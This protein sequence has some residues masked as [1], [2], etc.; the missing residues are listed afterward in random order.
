MYFQ[1]PPDGAA[2]ALLDRGTSSQ[3]AGNG[4]TRPRTK[5]ITKQV[6][7][8]AMRTPM[9]NGD[10]AKPNS[11]QSSK[12]K[13]PKE[14][15][16]EPDELTAINDRVN[17]IVRAFETKPLSSDDSFRTLGQGEF[18]ELRSNIDHLFQQQTAQSEGRTAML[19]NTVA[20]IDA[21]SEAGDLDIDQQDDESLLLMSDSKQGKVHGTL[22]EV[23]QHQRQSMA[24]LETVHK[25][26]ADIIRDLMARIKELQQ[27]VEEEH[28]KVLEQRQKV[29]DVTMSTDE[30][31]HDLEKH[32]DELNNAHQEIKQLQARLQKELEKPPPI[33]QIISEDGLEKLRAE[34]ERTKRKLGKAEDQLLWKA[35][36]LNAALEQQNAVMEQLGQAEAKQRALMEEQSL[37]KAKYESQ[38]IG[39]RETTSLL[40]QKMKDADEQ[41]A[42]HAAELL[43]VK[44][45]AKQAAEEA[46]TRLSEAWGSVHDQTGQ[47]EAEFDEQLAKAT[48]EFEQQLAAWR[49]RATKAELAAAE[50]EAKASAAA[51]VAQ[52]AAAEKAALEA[53]ALEAAS[54]AAAA[55]AA[56][57]QGAEQSGQ[58]E[59]SMVAKHK[60]E[61][62]EMRAKYEGDIAALRDKY[63]KEIRELKAAA[64][65]M[66]AQAGAALIEAKSKSKLGP[67]D[68]DRLA[69]QEFQM[70]QLK[71]K[72]AEL[73]TALKSAW[74]ELDA[75]REKN[76]KASE[77]L[78]SLRAEN[79][80]LLMDN[81][82]LRMD[83][84]TLRSENDA[85][86]EKEE[87]AAAAVKKA[88]DE[89]AAAVKVQAAAR[90][91]SVRRKQEKQLIGFKRMGGNAVELDQPQEEPID[92][93]VA[94]E[95][96]GAVACALERDIRDL[97]NDLARAMYQYK[98]ARYAQE[99]L[100]DANK[101]LRQENE[102]LVEA[103]RQEKTRCEEL[104]AKEDVS[105]AELSQLKMTHEEALKMHE[106]EKEHIRKHAKEEVRE[107]V[108]VL[109]AHFS[110]QMRNQQV[111][112]SEESQ[113]SS[114]SS[115]P[116]I[117][118]AGVALQ[119]HSAPLI[120]TADF[121]FDAMTK[122]IADEAESS[123]NELSEATAKLTHTEEKL[124]VASA[125]IKRYTSELKQLQ[126]N[127]DHLVLSTEAKYNDLEKAK[128]AVDL[129]LGKALQREEDQ[130]AEIDK[131]RESFAA[132]QREVMQRDAQLH[133]LREEVQVLE[134]STSSQMTSLV[135]ALEVDRAMFQ[136]QIEI[137]TAELHRSKQGDTKDRLKAAMITNKMA[138]NLKE[139]N[140]EKPHDELLDAMQL[141][142]KIAE[143]QRDLIRSQGRIDVLEQE[144]EKNREAI[145]SLESEKA[146]QQERINGLED[147]WLQAQARA[148]QLQQDVQSLEASALAA[149][150][151]LADMQRQSTAQARDVAGKAS[152]EAAALAEK[153]LQR[154][155]AAE[156]NVQ[157]VQRAA[158]DKIASLQRDM[159][160]LMVAVRSQQGTP[161]ERRRRSPEPTS[162][163][164]GMLPPAYAKLR[165][166]MQR[167]EDAILVLLKPTQ[168]SDLTEL[169]QAVKTESDHAST[170]VKA[171]V[172]RLAEL[173]ESLSYV[174]RLPSRVG[175]ARS[176]P[177][178]VRGEIQSTS[179]T[180]QGWVNA[181]QL[182]T[183]LQ[184]P[185]GA[186]EPTAAILP[187]RSKEARPS[188]P[189]AAPAT[190][191]GC[192]GAQ[193]GNMTPI[194]DVPA[195][196]SLV[197]IDSSAP[198]TFVDHYA[199]E[200][201]RPTR[202]SSGYLET[203][204][205]PNV[206][207]RKATPR[208]QRLHPQRS[209]QVE[210]PGQAQPPRAGSRPRGKI[211]KSGSTGSILLDPLPRPKAVSPVQVTAGQPPGSQ[212]DVSAEDARPLKSAAELFAR[213]NRGMTPI[214][215][216]QR[217][218]STR[219]AWL[220]HAT[221][222]DEFDIGH[223]V[224]C[225][226][227]A[228]GGRPI[229]SAAAVRPTQA[230][231]HASSA[232]SFWAQELP[233]LAG[234]G[235]GMA[236]QAV[237]A[238]AQ[239]LALSALLSRDAAQLDDLAA[240]LAEILRLAD[241]ERHPSLVAAI[242]QAGVQTPDT[243]D[244]KPIMAAP[245]RH[246]LVL[247]LS[248]LSAQ[249][250][251]GFAGFVTTATPGEPTSDE[252][253]RREV[254]EL[255]RT[256]QHRRQADPENAVSPRFSQMA[257][258][259]ISKEEQLQRMKEVYRNQRAANQKSLARVQ[260][261]L[262]GMEGSSGTETHRVL[263]R[264]E[265]EHL[266]AAQRW[267][268]KS[269][270][271][272][273]E[274]KRLMEQTMKEFCKVVY[275][276]RAF[277]G[278]AIEHRTLVQGHLPGGDPETVP[279]DLIN[280]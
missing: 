253:F 267:E 220:A 200:E 162:A 39:L 254:A 258:A 35:E 116:A 54:A 259:I 160:K 16:E 187:V 242:R 262:E 146:G 69:Q 14:P 177:P 108:E 21:A 42:A 105:K 179:A 65:A 129:A 148:E 94:H 264:M 182:G 4:Q 275:V 227:L 123:A 59:K 234:S 86:K 7:G 8:S 100:Q 26:E 76:K 223:T 103:L 256:L 50:S 119:S 210:I 266:E 120:S 260:K 29:V 98:S 170:I 164:D 278:R 136:D 144:G 233:Q 277:Q 154:A 172:R 34:L 82:T 27:K 134:L 117:G 239:E 229:T 251:Y 226:P 193:A 122:K 213:D 209:A 153:Y 115:Q 241:E 131:L 232:R 38:I 13:K 127:Y 9:P 20:S 48:A 167:L 190:K 206:R 40:Q 80:T 221:P 81:S 51:L 99:E 202:P 5:A 149:K 165:G 22:G 273:E 56:A 194:T 216:Q 84:S 158:E 75:L 235:P 78:E 161:V 237:A 62:D 70:S 132:S 228:V 125:E 55:A 204:V 147:D 64:E 111:Q 77:E 171:D 104:T 107:K 23:S 197:A 166:Q 41:L 192:N 184:L 152:S 249:T 95:R 186:N 245:T 97:E 203:G 36:E 169:L 71:E 188:T 141:K 61:K 74:E 18:K 73:T 79:S 159:S 176:S 255:R 24:K 89:D 174:Q 276:N 67:F 189:G 263:Q 151:A 236:L 201:L 156:A 12:P 222:E 32:K 250:T 191:S 155:L 205:G 240:S 138:E 58:T 96:E 157:T 83:N 17:E 243:K 90:G 142:M 272:Q 252:K 11:D 271:L 44:E 183:N 102:G 87:N 150:S 72:N 145:A 68:A 106:A 257:Q 173:A 53:A 3:R 238:D 231:A 185:N 211:I 265:K 1:A 19:A 128:M 199:E 118:T 246:D 135:G 180:D 112:L 2:K 274:R 60:K 137:L 224:T 28:M 124:A 181:S 101:A 25:K 195:D 126:M 280:S 63:E 178:K 114:S 133:A 168:A 57:A 268:Y 91:S 215:R 247:L 33:D 139:A 244:A 219:R 30:L 92:P 110:A 143:L 45:K 248:A 218:L 46:A 37:L 261:H 66:K 230:T 109:T 85:Y 207:S 208:E 140:E 88:E 269:V 113:T 217:Q 10:P 52:S 196:S 175:S 214:Q 212:V 279:T 270:C 6:V 121:D 130:Q 93:L 15:K 47:N 163:T 31:R 43:D 198:R 49:A 225:A